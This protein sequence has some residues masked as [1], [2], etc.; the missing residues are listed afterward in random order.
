MIRVNVALHDVVI[1]A[2]APVVHSTFCKTCGFIVHLPHGH[3]A[4]GTG[5]LTC[6]FLW[7]ENENIR[8]FYL[9]ITFN[10]IQNIGNTI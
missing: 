10:N 5:H 7:F 9:K 3:V 1:I 4:C 2:I 6:C 8:F